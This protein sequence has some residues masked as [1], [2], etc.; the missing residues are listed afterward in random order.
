MKTV[1]ISGC[2]FKVRVNEVPLAERLNPGLSFINVLGTKINLN[3]DREEEAEETKEFGGEFIWSKQASLGGGAFGLVKLQMRDKRGEAIS[4]EN[5]AD[6]ILSSLANQ[7][8]QLITVTLTRVDKVPQIL[9]CGKRGKGFEL[10]NIEELCGEAGTSPRIEEGRGGG[11]GGGG[12]IR[13]RKEK[14][15]LSEA[16][17][18]TPYYAVSPQEIPSAN[19]LLLISSLLANPYQFAKK[20]SSNGGDDKDDRGRVVV[21]SPAFEVELSHESCNMMSMIG[22]GSDSSARDSILLKVELPVADDFFVLKVTFNGIN[23]GGEGDRGLFLSVV[24]QLNLDF[25]ASDGLIPEGSKVND[26]FMYMVWEDTGGSTERFGRGKYVG[27]DSKRMAAQILPRRIVKSNRM[28]HEMSQGLGAGTKLPVAACIFDARNDQ[29]LSSVAANAINLLACVTDDIHSKLKV[30][31]TV[32]VNFTGGDFH[33]DM[34][35]DDEKGEVE[36][37][38]S[39]FW[40]RVWSIQGEVET[41][42]VKAGDLAAAFA[43]TGLAAFQFGSTE[44]LTL[45]AVLFKYVSDRCG[46]SGCAVKKFNDKRGC[47]IRVGKEFVVDFVNN[48]VFK[49][50]GDGDG[51]AVGQDEGGRGGFDVMDDLK[52]SGLLKRVNIG[53]DLLDG[54]EEEEIE[55]GVDIKGGTKR[56]IIQVVNVSPMYSPMGG[57]GGS[58]GGNNS[59]KAPNTPRNPPFVPI[60]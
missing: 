21:V 13:S 46:M 33:V 26:G 42:A 6:D 18:R 29:K 22:S 2:P 38:V 43:K 11:G 52:T 15:R 49:V 5:V 34:A 4:L 30:L 54:G 50:V 40:Q 41:L 12:G 32:V 8:K 7:M 10:A 3:R 28:Y 60:S 35:T 53:E 17:I 55:A 24:P 59:P 31:L 44:L 47:E 58:G 20:F 27:T 36:R 9:P 19:N 23:I 56:P 14:V 45:R 1:K 51:E 57:G 25:S 39:R 37:E 16:A 48:A